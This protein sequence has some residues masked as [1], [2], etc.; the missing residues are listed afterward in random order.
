MGSGSGHYLDEG[1]ILMNLHNENFFQ[2]HTMRMCVCVYV[3]DIASDKQ[4]FKNVSF[5]LMIMTS[6]FVGEFSF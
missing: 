3:Y 4:N 1:N 6:D 2:H 5:I